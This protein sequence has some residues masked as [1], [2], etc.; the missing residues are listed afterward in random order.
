MELQWLQKQTEEPQAPKPMPEAL[1][2][3]VSPGLADSQVLSWQL[4]HLP[5]PCSQLHWCSSS[6]HH[7]TFTLSHGSSPKTTHF[8][9]STNIG[10]RSGFECPSASGPFYVGDSKTSQSASLKER[11]WCVPQV[12]FSQCPCTNKWGFHWL[13][14][15]RDFLVPS[16]RRPSGA[17][18]DSTC[19]IDPSN[20]LQATFASPL[21]SCSRPRTSFLFPPDAPFS[22]HTQLY[23]QTDAGENLLKSQRSRLHCAL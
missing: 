16:V 4:L 18:V 15:T 5:P 2:H 21:K 23:S 20:L 1:C 10:L 9:F 19:Q 12:A 8:S 11:Y 7:E 3:Q 22:P 14:L 6:L 13:S 17:A